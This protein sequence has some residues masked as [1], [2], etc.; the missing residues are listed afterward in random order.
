MGNVGMMNA[1]CVNMLNS[2]SVTPKAK[3]ILQQI[4]ELR[5]LL[6]V[7]MKNRIDPPHLLP[8]EDSKE[9]S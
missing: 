7:E 6:E 3:E 9:V 5:Y 8:L 2:E 4:Q 1:F